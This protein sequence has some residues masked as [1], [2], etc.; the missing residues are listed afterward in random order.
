MIFKTRLTS[1]VLK[2]LVS[3]W[4]FGAFWKRYCTLSFYMFVFY[5]PTCPNLSTRMMMTGYRRPLEEKDLWSLNA[6]DCSHTVVPQ[7][8]K[9][10]NTQCQ[11]FK[12]SGKGSNFFIQMQIVRETS[13]QVNSAFSSQVRGENAVLVQASAPQ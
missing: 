6:E 13:S 2:L 9:R 8:V 7:L 4:S 12:R 3:T 1:S 11:K 5:P 10:W